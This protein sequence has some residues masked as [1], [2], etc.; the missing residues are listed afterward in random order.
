MPHIMQAFIKKPDDCEKGL[1]FDRK[2]YIARMVFEKRDS[3]TYVVSCSSR[4]IVYK[5]MFLVKQLR[6][7][8]HDLNSPDYHSAIGIVHSRFSTNT[9]PTWSLA[10]PFRLL[11][12]NGEINT[13]RGNRGWMEARESVLPLRH[14][15]MSKTS[16]PLSSRA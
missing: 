11:A 15:G 10:Q 14:W 6:L 7:F 4:T 2:L 1:E 13:I 12:H 8:Y 5:G 16:V 3:E 9:F